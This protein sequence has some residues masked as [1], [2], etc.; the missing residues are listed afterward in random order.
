MLS[1]GRRPDAIG[2]NG[3]IQRK[4]EEKK[5]MTREAPVNLFGKEG[6]S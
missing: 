3:M 2:P 4:P 6:K 5:K 1:V